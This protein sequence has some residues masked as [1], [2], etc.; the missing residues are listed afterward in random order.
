MD[1]IYYTVIL[2]AHKIIVVTQKVTLRKIY[3]QTEVQRSQFSS[4]LA[5]PDDVIRYCQVRGIP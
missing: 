4:F 5:F 1:I 3:Q 2:V